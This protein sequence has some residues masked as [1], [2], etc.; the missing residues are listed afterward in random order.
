MATFIHNSSQVQGTIL[1]IEDTEDEM[2]E[3]RMDYFKI[4]ASDAPCLFLV[5]G[6]CAVTD[7]MLQH[8]PLLYHKLNCSNHS[9]RSIYHRVHNS[10]TIVI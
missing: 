4:G 10:L 6:F 3:R 8:D 9:Y 5:S 7:K 2:T 1:N